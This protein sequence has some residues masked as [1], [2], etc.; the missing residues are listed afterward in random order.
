MSLAVCLLTLNTTFCILLYFAEL[1]LVI[2]K[3]HFLS[4]YK[5]FL[6]FSLYISH[7]C[8]AF[9]TLLSKFQWTTNNKHIKETNAQ[10]KL[11][12]LKYLFILGDLYFLNCATALLS[13]GIIIHW[14]KY[15]TALT[16]A[17][18]YGRH[19]FSHSFVITGVISKHQT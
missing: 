2:S 10:S 14:K 16:P 5:I 3:E 18:T 19:S 6:N 9:P 12:L 1:W 11:N 15:N 8:L 7:V 17:Q 13:N 4:S